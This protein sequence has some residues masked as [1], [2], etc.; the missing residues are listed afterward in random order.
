M[1][2]GEYARFQV[3]EGEVPSTE[4]GSLYMSTLVDGSHGRYVLH[5]GAPNDVDCH[6]RSGQKRSDRCIG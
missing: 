6:G 4:G 5:L 1:F 3:Y 2:T